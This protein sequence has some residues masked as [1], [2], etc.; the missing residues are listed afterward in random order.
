MPDLLTIKEIAQ[1]LGI[2]ESNI[3]YYRDKFESYL[4]YEGEGRKRR[5][6][7]EAQE[8]FAYIKD[9]FGKNK[10]GE[11]IERDLA[12]KFAVN[13]RP[14]ESDLERENGGA[15]GEPAPDPG[16]LQA[17]TMQSKALQQMAEVVNQSRLEERRLS[18]LETQN[19]K[20]K[21]ALYLMWQNQKKFRLPSGEKNSDN[22]ERNVAADENRV[23]D[24]EERMSKL[25]D[26]QE[27]LRRSF[28]EQMNKLQEC[29]RRCQF[30]TKRIM[31]QYAPEEA[32]RFEDDQ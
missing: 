17:L 21:R 26:E 28:D 22:E 16:N 25:A 23:R 3:R 9:Q 11:E 8:I 19:S 14:S 24:L 27:N 13:A 2:P 4:P 7:P 15:A 30:W 10:T 20:M 31:L 12:H 32:D 6:R 1:N 5:Y 18:R 29:M